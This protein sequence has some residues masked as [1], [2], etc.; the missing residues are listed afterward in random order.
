MDQSSVESIASYVDECILIPSESFKL[1]LSTFS[2][3]QPDD[4]GNLLISKRAIEAF[5]SSIS[6]A[7]ESTV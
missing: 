7:Y 5:R 3:H 2:S 6:A 1:T 4:E